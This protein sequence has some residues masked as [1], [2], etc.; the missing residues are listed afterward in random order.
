MVHR[1]LAPSTDTVSPFCRPETI[2]VITGA[3]SPYVMLLDDA[4]IDS[5]AG[6]IV[7]VPPT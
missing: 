6:V 3:G 4:V 1:R 7:T 2:A 5:A